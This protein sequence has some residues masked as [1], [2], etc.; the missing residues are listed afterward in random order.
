M[1]VTEKAL[2]VRDEDTRSV[3]RSGAKSGAEYF[4]SRSYHGL[5]IN[6]TESL[7]GKFLAGRSGKASGYKDEKAEKS[8]S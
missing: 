3:T 8:Q 4:A 1:N 7:P 6:S 5:D 2:Q